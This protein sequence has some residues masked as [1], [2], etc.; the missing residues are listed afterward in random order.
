[1]LFLPIRF[2]FYV[3]FVTWNMPFPEFFAI[4]TRWTGPSPFSRSSHFKKN[5]RRNIVFAN[6]DDFARS[7]VIKAQVN[8]P[9]PYLG[10]L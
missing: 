3:Y 1:M 4:P 7:D 5:P 2:G 6:S 10:Q 8:L 9:Y